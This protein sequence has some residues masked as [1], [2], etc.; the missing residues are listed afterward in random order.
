MVRGQ[1]WGKNFIM[2][3]FVD[4]I[5]FD[6]SI[7]CFRL[8]SCEIECVKWETAKELLSSQPWDFRIFLILVPWEEEEE[9]WKKRC[10]RRA[11]LRLLKTRMGL[12]ALEYF[13][14]YIPG[15]L[16]SFVKRRTAAL[17][18]NSTN[19]FFG[20]T[21]LSPQLI[22]FRKWILKYLN[23]LTLFFQ[24]NKT[25][26]SQMTKYLANKLIVLSLC[27]FLCGRKFS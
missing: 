8:H 13:W 19:P 3:F 2:T 17:R 18:K 25:F 21:T 26:V 6:V 5:F 11:A 12:F 9:K 22:L 4:N 1:V 10:S 20:L 23:H 15:T 16:R 27:L 24:S 14:N 7:H